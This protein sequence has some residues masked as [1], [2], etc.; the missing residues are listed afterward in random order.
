MN[1]ERPFTLDG[2]VFPCGQCLP[3]RIITRRTWQHRI[4]LEASEHA[5]NTFVT[6][7]YAD[8]HLP[9]DQS[10]SPR[11]ITLFIKRL[12][13]AIPYPIR[14]FACGEYG[15]HTFRP[16]YHLALFGYPNCRRHTTRHSRN[17]E[18]CCENCSTI[19]RTWG[20]GH[21]SLGV[22]EPASAAYIAAYTTKKMTRDDDPRLEGR[23]PE[24]ARMS[25]R[26]GIGVGFLWDLA[27]A[28]MEHELDDPE[29]MVDVPFSIDHG[30]MSFPLG[31]FM[32]RKLRT[33][34]GR[35]EGKPANIGQTAWQARKALELQAMREIAF[36]NSRPLTQEILKASLGRRIQ[37][38]AKYQRRQKKDKL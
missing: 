31:R 29:K 38:E 3:C 23:L 27:S 34:L 17:A 7:T 15:E 32:R 18:P 1:C 28:I 33:F 10:V 5:D 2:Q 36:K 37:I 35:P 12:R 25:R 19:E 9:I 26:P 4:M 30:T 21:I 20:L 11:A 24:F 8:K 13:K 6:L 14:Y 22:L 16:H